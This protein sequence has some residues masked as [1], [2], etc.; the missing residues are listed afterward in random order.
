MEFLGTGI[1]VTF[2]LCTLLLYYLIKKAKIGHKHEAKLPPGSMGLP[3]FGET[4]QLYSQDPN[5]LFATKQKRFAKC[6]FSCFCVSVNIRRSNMRDLLLSDIIK[7]AGMEM[8]SKLTF[9]AALA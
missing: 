4:L 7:Y 6:C 1:Y 8:Y 9:L 3:Y 5:V 2:F